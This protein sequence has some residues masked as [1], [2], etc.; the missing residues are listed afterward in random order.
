ME[1]QEEPERPKAVT[2][3]GRLWLI[4]AGFFVAQNVVDLILWKILQPAMPSLL[5]LARQRE[6]QTRFLG[7]LLEHYAAW[8]TIQIL[9]AAS[10]G[11]AA[12]FFLRLR[13]WARLAIQA[14]CWI[15]LFYFAAF[16]VFWTRIWGRAFVESVKTRSLSARSHGA[17]TFLAG[18]GVCLAI[19][20]GLTWLIGLL[21]SRRVKAAFAPAPAA[22]GQS[23]AGT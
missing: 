8:K 5:E 23:V 12:F 11:I 9:L 19:V 1:S 15:V 20:A 21:R 2:V 10:V 22:A 16:G 4:V 14:V 13:P 18:V 6:P 3:I 17:I 7:P